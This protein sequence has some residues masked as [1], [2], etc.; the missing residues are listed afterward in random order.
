MADESVHRRCEIRSAPTSVEDVRF[1]LFTEEALHAFEVALE[2][3][4]H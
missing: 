4:A 3:S 2:E 1:V